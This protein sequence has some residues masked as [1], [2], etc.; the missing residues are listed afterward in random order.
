LRALFLVALARNTVVAAASEPPA[1]PEVTAAMQP[2]LKRG[3]SKA[4]SYQY[5]Q[6]PISL[7][8]VTLFISKEKRQQGIRSIPK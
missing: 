2:Y 4:N 6:N 5:K 8:N 1:S 7:N 3:A